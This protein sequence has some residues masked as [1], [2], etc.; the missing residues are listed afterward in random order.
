MFQVFSGFGFA[1]PIFS[2]VSVFFEIDIHILQQ[3]NLSDSK[4][5]KFLLLTKFTKELNC[6]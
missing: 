5:I 4:N 6:N 3:R 1:Y 2:A